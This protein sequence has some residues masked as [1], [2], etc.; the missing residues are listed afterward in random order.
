MLTF[1]DLLSGSGDARIAA[2]MDGFTRDS[3]GRIER[4]IG[5][6]WVAAWAH[7]LA[8]GER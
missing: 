4:H 2:D 5:S 3:A 7:G 6:L 1:C 8:A